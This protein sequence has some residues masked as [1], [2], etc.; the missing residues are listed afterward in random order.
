LPI[1]R[2]FKIATTYYTEHLNCHYCDELNC[3][4]L[5]KSFDIKINNKDIYISFNILTNSFGQKIVDYEI[6]A[7]LYTVSFFRNRFHYIEF[8]NKILIE[9]ESAALDYYIYKLPVYNHEGRQLVPHMYNK[10]NET[11]N[12]K[13]L[14]IDSRFIKMLGI[15][16]Y[17]NPNPNPNPNYDE[18]TETIQL[19]VNDLNPFGLILLSYHLFYNNYKNRYNLSIELQNRINNFEILKQPSDDFRITFPVSDVHNMNPKDNLTNVYFNIYESK[20]RLNDDGYVI[21]PNRIRYNYVYNHQ[22]NDI[23]KRKEELDKFKEYT[24][25]LT[26]EVVPSIPKGG[27]TFNNNTSPNI[28]LNVIDELFYR[29]YLKY[30]KKYLKLKKM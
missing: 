7:N 22:I 4:K 28:D 24:L 2:N 19:V 18:Y 27:Y 30:K 14:D 16:N 13:I 17:I 26:D 3:I 25:R 11:H 6:V 5:F 8:N 20:L 10:S 23:Q 9:I 15:K 1:L 29:K 21:E 12:L